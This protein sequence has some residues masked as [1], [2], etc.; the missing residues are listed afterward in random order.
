MIK[1]IAANLI[2][3]PLVLVFVACSWVAEV[4]EH[5]IWAINGWFYKEE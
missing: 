3:L 2:L 4:C 1:S 5:I